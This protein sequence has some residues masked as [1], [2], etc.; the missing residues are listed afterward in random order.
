L[1]TLAGSSNRIKLTWATGTNRSKGNE[2]AAERAKAGT[3][4]PLN[5]QEP[6]C[7]ISHAQ[8]RV[9]VGQWIFE[10][11]RKYWE[12]TP[13]LHTAKQLVGPPQPVRK[14]ELLGFSRQK[15]RRIVAF[16][17][18]HAPCK[19]HLFRMGLSD[20]PTCTGC[21]LEDET[22]LHVMCHC[23]SYATGRR[24]LLG[25]DEIPPDQIMQTP[26]KTLLEFIEYTGIMRE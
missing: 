16:L 3:D 20:Q 21:E 19:K 6:A 25:G 13:R 17:T 9:A 15:I 4:K 2:I 11:H 12:E 14:N 10:Q 26:L 18:G 23:R 1:T 8:V 24:R 22:T 5:N 7:G